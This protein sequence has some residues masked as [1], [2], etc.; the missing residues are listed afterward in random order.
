ME[1]TQETTHYRV[2]G[3]DKVA[4]GPLDLAALAQ[5]IQEERLTRTSWVFNERVERWQNA[6]DLAELRPYFV[7]KDRA[8]AGG[9]SSDTSLQRR[10]GL[11]PEALRSIRLFANLEDSQLKSFLHYLEVVRFPQFS[12]IVRQGQ[13]GDAM[14]VV[15]EGEL[16]VLTIVDGKESILATLTAGDCFGEISLLD[17][18]PR[19]ADV[20]ANRDSVLLRLSNSAFE[21]LVREAPALSVPFLLALSR[22]VVHSIRHTNKKYEDSI[23]FIRASATTRSR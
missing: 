8:D 7:A 5:W 9:A 23:R 14:Y 4:Y 21:R 15:V 11:P 19:S 1:T 2:W 3:A 12:H 13:R 16:R 18:G 10:Y 17:Q 20:I 6:V 22:A